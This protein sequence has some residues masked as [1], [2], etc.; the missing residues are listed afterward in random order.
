MIC[1]IIR[2]RARLVHSPTRRA[3][4]SRPKSNA[5][6]ARTIPIRIDASGSKSGLLKSLLRDIPRNARKVP[7]SPAESQKK[8]TIDTAQWIQLGQRRRASSSSNASVRP[9]AISSWGPSH[10]FSCLGETNSD[11]LFPALPCR[12]CETLGTH[13]SGCSGN[14]LAPHTREAIR[15][16]G[17]LCCQT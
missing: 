12:L 2:M 10:L 16:A 4:V 9:C 6:R 5:T 3:P 13:R 1:L 17:K 8:V 14:R 11:G 7:M 15:R